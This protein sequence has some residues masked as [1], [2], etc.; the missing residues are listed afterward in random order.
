MEA[1]KNQVTADSI[2]RSSYKKVMRQ[3]RLFHHRYFL[4]HPNKG[5]IFIHC[6]YALA[7]YYRL[8]IA[9]GRGM[10]ATSLVGQSNILINDK[11][12]YFLELYDEDEHLIGREK[13]VTLERGSVKF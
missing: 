8:L 12:L 3:N 9:L 13:I 5:Q 4:S 2:D 1:S 7:D 10:V 6:Q 11:G